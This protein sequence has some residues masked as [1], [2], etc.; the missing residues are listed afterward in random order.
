MNC[1]PELTYS[2]YLDRELSPEESHA[3]EAH[4]ADCAACR[5]RV[6]GLRLENQLLAEALDEG[7]G[8]LAA[9][10]GQTHAS[11]PLA[12]LLPAMLGGVI[13]LSWTLRSLSSYFPMSANWVNP[14]SRTS[15]LN[16]L[17]SVAFF[18]TDQ[19]ETIIHWFAIAVTGVAA[20][21]LVTAAIY[22]LVRRWPLHFAL[23]ATA[24]L[25]AGFAKPASAMETRNGKQVVTVPANETVSDSLAAGAQSVEVAG[26]INGNL[27][28]HGQRITIT[29]TVTGDV[30]T[31]SQILDI[32]GTVEGN[33]FSWAQFITVRGKVGQ[34][35]H[36]FAESFD[37]SNGGQVGG[38]VLAFCATVNVSGN[39]GGDVR[40]HAGSVT[41][42]GSVGR[43]LDAAAGQVA[44]AGSA[45]VGHNLTAEVKR[46]SDFSMEPGAVIG[47]KIEV[48]LSGASVS[49][50]LTAHFYLWKAVHLGAIWVTGLVLFWLFPFLFKGK[51]DNSSDLLKAIGWGFVVLVATPVAAVIACLTVVGLPLAI[52]AMALWL[53][54]LYVAKLFLAAVIGQR[55]TGPG[56]GG[57]K[58][59]AAPLLLGL[60]IIFVAIELP[61]IGRWD[62]LLV[63]LIGYGLV[64]S[65]AREAWARRQQLAA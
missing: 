20:G 29:G 3:V 6:E 4:L 27:I 8:A 16:F 24:L 33:V 21:L 52:L 39:V 25:F 23:L 55:L 48:K 12:W 44:V 47:G 13:A 43:N 10:P 58:A 7:F 40:A 2:I 36:V 5:A 37:L 45:H 64:L 17:L 38:D 59:F 9:V 32:E 53:I 31:A 65:A 34:S 62:S 49:R 46:T 56:A 22:L 1:F 51:M 61:Y 26:K 63:I 50:F 19:R 54:G 57:R 11:F 41:L 42:H 35:V 18:L 28:A 15:L 60:L 30:I 14:F